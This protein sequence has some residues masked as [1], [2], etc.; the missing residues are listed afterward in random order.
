MAD[1]MISSIRGLGAHLTDSD[2]IMLRQI[3]SNWLTDEGH[4][5]SRAF[6]PFPKDDGCLSLSRM[7]MIAPKSSCLR[8]LEAGYQTVGVMG[9][10]VG[11][12]GTVGVPV[13]EHRL[14]ENDAHASAIYV[15]FSRRQSEKASKKL[16]TYA[17]ARNWLYQHEP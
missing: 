3:P 4:V 6:R 8:H 17:R 15:G 16:R 14:R 10:T 12:F 2:E 7:S 1:D 9:V 11:E 5:S 13:Y